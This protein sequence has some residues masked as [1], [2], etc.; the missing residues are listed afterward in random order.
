MTK[1]IDGYKNEM[2]ATHLGYI[3]YMRSMYH[4]KRNE[5]SYSFQISKDYREFDNDDLYKYAPDLMVKYDHFKPFQARTIEIQTGAY[6]CLTQED[7]PTFMKANQQA[8]EAAKELQKHIEI[9]I[10][11]HDMLLN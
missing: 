6:G 7:Y 11:F 2:Q 8:L 4:E 3:L 9:F 10:E 5:F 1:L